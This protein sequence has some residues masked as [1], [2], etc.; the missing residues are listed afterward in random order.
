M[1]FPLRASSTEVL[2]RTMKINCALRAHISRE[3]TGD[4]KPVPIYL[5]L[6]N[7]KVVIVAAWKEED[8][9]YE[10]NV[11]HNARERKCM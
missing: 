5:V 2:L 10:T 6:G 8:R 1:P 9:T 4:M 11:V 7:C 3:V